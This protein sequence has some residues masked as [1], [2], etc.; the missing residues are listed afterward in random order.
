[1]RLS[2]IRF[3]EISDTESFSDPP[4]ASQAGQSHTEEG[5]E[6]DD[7]NAASMPQRN[8]STQRPS[9]P[10]EE[11]ARQAV[12][13]RLNA[14]TSSQQETIARITIENCQAACFEFYRNNSL[15]RTKFSK[16]DS[17]YAQ[18]V[19]ELPRGQPDRC[20]MN[21]NL[22]QWIAKIRHCWQLRPNEHDSCCYTAVRDP[23]TFAQVMEKAERVPSLLPP[24]GG[25]DTENC[26]QRL[27]DAIIFCDHLKSCDSKARLQKLLENIRDITAE[28]DFSHLKPELSPKTVPLLRTG[29]GQ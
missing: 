21:F 4:K 12:I 3:S 22:S 17:P 18:K 28:L 11:A 27:E 19:F 24:W 20:H 13:Q 23:G 16:D 10:N 29:S 5:V 7:K 25:L 8:P 1:M 15:W 26:E 2:S 9:G 6:R 14:A